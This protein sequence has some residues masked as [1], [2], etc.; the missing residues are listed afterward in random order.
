M[1]IYRESIQIKDYMRCLFTK[2]HNCCWF[3]IIPMFSAFWTIMV[4]N[5]LMPFTKD[6]MRPYYMGVLLRLIELLAPIG[7]WK[8]LVIL[9]V[10]H[11]YLQLLWN[12]LNH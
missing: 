11:V 6:M 5:N 12:E 1:L 2:I 3:R 7:S 10:A 9:D 4:F 8:L